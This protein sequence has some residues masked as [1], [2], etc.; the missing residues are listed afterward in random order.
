MNNTH[1]IVNK[2]EFLRFTF[3]KKLCCD[4]EI[5]RINDMVVFDKNFRACILDISG[6]GM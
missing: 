6:S 4:C 1:C 5:T 3:D 2:R